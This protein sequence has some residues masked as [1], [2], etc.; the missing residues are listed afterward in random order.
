MISLSCLADSHPPAIITWYQLTP[1]KQVILVMVMM[2]I[3][4]MMTMMMIIIIIII[5]KEVYFVIFSRFLVEVN[6]KFFT[7]NDFFISNSFDVF[8]TNL[9]F[10][11]FS[12]H[13]FHFLLHF[14][15]GATAPRLFNHSFLECLQLKTCAPAEK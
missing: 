13:Q 8:M 7:T 14:P 4:M 12:H 11:F 15:S 1:N 3:M 10:K 9:N 6:L 2:T 5:M